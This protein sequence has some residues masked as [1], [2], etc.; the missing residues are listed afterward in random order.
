MEKYVNF[1]IYIFMKMILITLN[2]FSIIQ[3][4]IVAIRNK[5]LDL[6]LHVIKIIRYTFKHM[7]THIRH[8]TIIVL[9][10]YLIIIIVKH[11]KNILLVRIKAF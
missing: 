2:E 1:H 4:I 11:L 10:N 3:K 5:L 7:S 8:F 9:Y 6:T